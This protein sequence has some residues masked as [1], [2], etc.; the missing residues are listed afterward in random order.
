MGDWIWLSIHNLHYEGYLMT[1]LL[2]GSAEP[3][4]LF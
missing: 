2:S 4:E 3:G 1:M